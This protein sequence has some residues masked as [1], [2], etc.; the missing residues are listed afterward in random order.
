[1][2]WTRGVA[3]AFDEVLYADGVPTVPGGAVSATLSKDGGAFEALGAGSSITLITGTPV[4]HA[5]L[6]VADMTCGGG[7]LK[8][9]DAGGA[10]D[11][12]YVTF[13]TEEDYTEELATQLG[14]LSGG[15]GV[16]SVVVTVVEGATPFQGVRVIATNV[17]ESL[18][19]AIGHTDVNGQC[20]FHLDTDT[21]RII[22]GA[23]SAQSG[24]FVDVVVDGPETVTIEVTS[25]VLP[26]PT[27]PDNY[28]LYDYENAIEGNAPDPAVA[29]TVRVLEVD[30]GAQNDATANA[31]SYVK[32]TEFAVDPV[33]GYWGFEIS[34]HLDGYVLTLEKEW[35][36]ASGRKKKQIWAAPIDDAQASPTDQMCWADLAPERYRA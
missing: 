35:T 33:T 17:A 24:G 4:V 18:T 34:K 12:R 29:M 28:L 30:A 16:N 9:V 2:A 31:S 15:L 7:T 1:M 10:T 21:W 6:G 26:T 13:T 22:A 3:Q 27:A 8:I 23:N 11:D 25:S 32:G 19:P 14:A 20:T 5:V 36:L